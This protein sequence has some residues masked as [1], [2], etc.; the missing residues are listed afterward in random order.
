MGFYRNAC[1]SC[2]PACDC[3]K[4]Y[5]CPLIQCVEENE[6]YNSDPKATEAKCPNLPKD[7]PSPA[8]GSVKGCLCKAGYYRNRNGFCVNKAECLQTFDCSNPC[9]KPNEEF[10]CTN[11]CF[12]RSCY[13]QG[14]KWLVACDTDPKCTWQCDCVKG[15][16]RDVAGVC[17]PKSEKPCEKK[18]PPPP[19]TC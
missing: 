5:H 13:A 18:D 10:R 11:L 4:V 2:V 8:P 17:R 19:Q 12:Q 9:N 6:V 1:G 16:L 14:I 7:T 15:Y 3:N